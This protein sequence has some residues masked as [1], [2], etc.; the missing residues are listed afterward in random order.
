MFCEM[1]FDPP[2]NDL[3]NL[4][5]QEVQDG[6]ALVACAEGAGGSP[7]LAFGGLSGGSAGGLQ[8]AWAC[9]ETQAVGKKPG[10]QTVEAFEID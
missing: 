1:T 5:G 10:E 4:V 8:T 6:W 2:Q 7:P 3:P 9:G